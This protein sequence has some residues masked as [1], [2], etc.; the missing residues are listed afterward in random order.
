[1]MISRFTVL[2]LL[3]LSLVACSGEQNEE[4]RSLG[5]AENCDAALSSCRVSDGAI[6]VVLTM[7]PGV[8][9]LQPFPFTLLIEGGEVAAQSVV[10]DFQMQGMEMGTN[11]Y[12][13]QPQQGNWQATVTLP[14]CSASR[15]DWLAVV[16]FTLD[17]EPLQAVFPFHTEAN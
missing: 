14:V 10:A 2:S 15:M 9:P 13:L 8:K 1:M 5:G 6:S 3:L 16:E 11:R 17:G 7:G 12:R 4:R